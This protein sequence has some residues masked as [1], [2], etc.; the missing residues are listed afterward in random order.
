MSETITPFV[1][2]VPQSELDDL[3][4]R[5]DH[6]RLP[7]REPAEGWSQGVPLD[8]LRALID[9][10]RNDYDW[11][12]CEAMLNGFG[13]FKTQIDGLDIHFL[14]IR[15]P[16]ADAMPMLLTHGWPGSVIEFHKVIGPLT[17]PVAHG[18]DVSDAF[19]LV[20]PSL[21]GYGFSGKPAETGWGVE[22]T[23]RAWAELMRRLGYD[24][25]VAQGGDWG[26]AV[27]V[28]L[29]V[30][31]PQGLAGVHFNMLSIR[32]D[33]LGPELDADEEKAI[34]QLKH[35]ADVES[36]YA[37]LQATRP[38]TIGYCLADSPVGQ[39]AWIYE[40]LRGWSDCDG[41]PETIFTYDEMLDNIMLYWLTNSGAS[42]ARLY[43]ESMGF[44]RPMNIA[45]PL[46]YSQF[47][48]EIMSPPRKW[49]E[50]LFSNII[51]WNNVEKGGHFAAF[52]QPEIF[53]NEVR[54][55]FRQ[56]RG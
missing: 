1:L 32:P 8:R 7:E 10:W 28:A 23:A 50:T 12:R 47:P 20:V 18:G 44:F 21:P 5:L 51:H 43:W 55:C 33:D 19:H 39:A 13:Q 16:H 29:G 53:V 37:R 36:A 40:K 46:G 41:E 2:A 25:Y 15:S 38:Q 27:T 52:E 34:G 9:Y 11:R 49:G 54:T 48:R 22:R 3:N 30:Q 26:S 17:D 24:R 14:H 35:F 56:L 31:A 6:A 4:Y 42:S 45:I